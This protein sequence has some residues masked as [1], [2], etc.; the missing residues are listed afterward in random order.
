M[1]FEV[2]FNYNKDNGICICVIVN[3]VA[4]LIFKVEENQVFFSHSAV[5]NINHAP[6]F[7]LSELS[8]NLCLLKQAANVKTFRIWY[9]RWASLAKH[10]IQFH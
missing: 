8:K 2:L 7:D 10:G 9:N 1:A 5:K 6:S 3:M 4:V